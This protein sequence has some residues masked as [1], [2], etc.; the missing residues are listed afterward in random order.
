MVR[1]KATIYLILF[2]KLKSKDK[3]PKKPIAKDI[4]LRMISLKIIV[5]T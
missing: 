3:F 1:G 2:V 5:K 4:A